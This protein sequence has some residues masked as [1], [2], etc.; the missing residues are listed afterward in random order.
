MDAGMAGGDQLS[1]VLFVVFRRVYEPVSPPPSRLFRLSRSVMR[2]P[3]RCALCDAFSAP[4]KDL[5]PLRSL[6]A[7]L[8]SITPVSLWI[9]TGCGNEEEVQI[10]P[11]GWGGWGG[12]VSESGAGSEGGARGDKRSSQ[13]CCL[14]GGG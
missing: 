4:A 10:K 6:F 13:L 1:G 11:Y 12:Q 5:P 7:H 14:S 8:F 9:Q 2:L 3:P